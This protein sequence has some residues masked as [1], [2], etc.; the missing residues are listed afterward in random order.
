M[1]ES[2]GELPDNDEEW[3]EILSDEEYRILRESGTEPRFSSDLIDVEDEGVFTCA[4]CG[5]E[6]FDSDR[7]FESETGWPSF[8]DVYQEGNV[9]TQADNSHGMERTEVVC[10]E[11]GGHLGHV[12]DDGPEPSGKRYCIN[13]AALDF[14]SE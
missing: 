9:E 7:K 14:E 1:S 12:F 6:L 13:G 2:E 8:W 5:T 11:C 10:A 3:R 4:G